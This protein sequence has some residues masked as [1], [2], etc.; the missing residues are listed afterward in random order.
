MVILIAGAYLGF[1]WLVGTAIPLKITGILVTAISSFSALSAAFGFQILSLRREIKKSSAFDPDRSKIVKHRLDKS[2]RSL[3]RRWFS[4]FA[5][6]ISGTSTGLAIRSDAF[7]SIDPAFIALFGYAFALL[8]VFF[9]YLMVHEYKVLS[10]FVEEMEEKHRKEEENKEW[11][12]YKSTQ[13]LK[14]TEFG[15]DSE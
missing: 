14:Q 6:G 1:F 8:S 13:N 9:L 7:P 3:N 4:S 5:C 15:S 11:A 10:A 12:K 2:L